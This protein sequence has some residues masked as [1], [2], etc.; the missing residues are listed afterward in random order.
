MGVA[1]PLY[2]CPSRCSPTLVSTIRAVILAGLLLLLAACSDS[3]DSPGVDQAA[4]IP[5][6]TVASLNLLHGLSC[7]PETADCRLADRQDLLFDWL[8]SIGCPDVVLLQEVTGPRVI[9][10]LTER[11]AT[12][13]DAVYQVLAP[14]SV[15]GQNYTLTRY[16][17]LQ[18]NEDRLMGPIRLLWHTQIDHPTGIVDV[19]NTHLAAGV[20]LQPCDDACPAECRAAGAVNSRECQALQAA[21]LVQQRAAPDSLRIFAGDFNADPQSF[22]YRHLV[23]EN[24]WGDAYLMAGNPE[25]DPTTGIGCTSGR[26]DE[27]LSDMESP[28]N[29]VSRRIDFLFV[30]MPASG[31]ASCHYELDSHR[32]E[33]GDSVATR[34]FADDPN[35]FAQN[36]G[37]LPEAICWPSDHEGMQA[38]INC[39]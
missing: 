14:P 26:Q 20:D 18:A 16:P 33:D 7:P 8:E 23:D 5:D 25:C 21:S 36:C 15:L 1:M 11:A 10:A 27:D 19:F 38:D 17:V 24:G 37:P 13:C 12:R 32:D 39:R 28:E 29:G 35:P 2:R 9:A 3:S 22:V 4:D 30:K 6:V 34:I 31:G